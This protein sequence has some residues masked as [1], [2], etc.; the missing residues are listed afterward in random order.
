MRDKQAETCAEAMQRRQNG[1]MSDKNEQP[2]GGRGKLGQPKLRILPQT[3]KIKRVR[4]LSVIVGEH[5]AT[6]KLRI[7]K[8]NGLA[9]SS[10][11]LL[12]S[13][14][15]FSQAPRLRGLKNAIY[16][17]IEIQNLQV[18][19]CLKALAVSAKDSQLLH[20]SHSRTLRLPLGREREREEVVARSCS[21]LERT[22]REASFA[23]CVSQATLRSSLIRASD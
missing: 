18:W 20:C 21:W 3:K 19:R 16:F 12:P 5:Q 22:L 11:F 23:M 6:R 1:N 8:R 15:R 7:S 13:F 17:R 10:A 9:I 4:T 2:G 14:M